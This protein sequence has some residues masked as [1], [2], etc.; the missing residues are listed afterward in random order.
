[1][2]LARSL[3][4]AVAFLLEL[5]LL[6]ALGVWGFTTVQGWP[7]IVL[8]LAAPLLAAVVWGIFLAPKA[9]RP[10]DPVLTFWLKGAMLSLGVVALALTNRPKLAI[11]FAVAI[12]INMLLLWLWRE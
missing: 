2:A 5:C 12:V 8:G 4:L 6:A 9:S 7:R 10:L 1:M 3:N 11:G